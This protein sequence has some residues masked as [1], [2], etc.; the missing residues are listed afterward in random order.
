MF[1]S[2]GSDPRSRGK[3]ELY[4]VHLQSAITLDPHTI[5]ETLILAKNT[6]NESEIEY[7]VEVQKM[8]C[9][10]MAG[11]SQENKHIVAD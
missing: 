9:S 11:A 10:C 8:S 6:N 2:C 4:A 3:I 5:T 1:F 7:D